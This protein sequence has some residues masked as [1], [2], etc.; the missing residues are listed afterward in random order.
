MSKG[1]YH[2]KVEGC[3]TPGGQRYVRITDGDQ[4]GYVR[5]EKVL[6]D[7]QATADDL[8]AQGYPLIGQGF[9]PQL[10][11]EAQA[12]TV[13]ERAEIAETVG[14]IGPIFAKP[15]GEV[16]LPEAS[17][18]EGLPPPGTAFFRLPERHSSKGKLKGWKKAIAPLLASSDM[19]RV[20]VGLALAPAVR[21]L[22]PE[23]VAACGIQLLV[24]GRESRPRDVL[25]SVIGSARAKSRGPDAIWELAENPSRHVGAARDHCL[26][27]DSI[28]GHLAGAWDKKRKAAFRKL[29]FDHLI[30]SGG[31]DD[32][33]HGQPAPMFV[34]V[35][36]TPLEDQ[37]DLDVSAADRLRDHL[38]TIRVPRDSFSGLAPAASRADSNPPTTDLF[39]TAESKLRSHYGAAL[40]SFLHALVERQAAGPKALRQ[41]LAEW[42]S[43][44]ERTAKKRVKRDERSELLVQQFAL[45]YAALRLATALDIVPKV[46]DN[47]KALLRVLEQALGEIPKPPT[48]AAR[49]AEIAALPDVLRVE[50][51]DDMA[52]EELEKATAFIKT[53]KGAR[54]ELWIP[55]GQHKDLLDWPTFKKHAD[56]DKC[57]L[58]KGEKDRFGTKRTIG[59]WQNVRVLRFRLP[60]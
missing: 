25:H 11:V 43:F 58:G 50:D 41:E 54:R 33:V 4:V 14:W 27:L 35:E 17:K 42:F 28:S 22:L 46:K 5:Y 3:K 44:F 40:D 24:E 47:G 60:D 31:G 26:L 21:N 29:L 18:V 30:A 7:A 36:A 10:R 8:L 2:I 49:L 57:F 15:N 38:L 55:S 32:N 1:F 23:P 12:L 39:A 19:T 20:L 13:F 53:I 9:I 52:V 16:I 6:T 51:V 48:A 59:P 34:A 45:V 56:F 37:L